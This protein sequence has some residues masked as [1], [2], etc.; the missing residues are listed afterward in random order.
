MCI[1]HLVLLVGLTFV[2][3]L[4]NGLGGFDIFVY[5]MLFSA[6]GRFD[7]CMYYLLFSGLGGF[8]RYVYYMLFS[9]PGRFDTCVYYLLFS[10]PGG[11][12]RDVYIPHGF[13]YK[14]DCVW[15]FGL[16]VDTFICYHCGYVSERWL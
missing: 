11:F 12:D 2:Y 5:Y 8:D 15:P 10:A 9:G 7:T 1:T 16:W 14:S 6:P 3:Y 13:L 4:F